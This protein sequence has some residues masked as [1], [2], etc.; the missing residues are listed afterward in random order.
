[1]LG[2]YNKKID[3]LPLE[4]LHYEI[5]KNPFPFPT[6]LKVVGPLGPKASYFSLSFESGRSA[7]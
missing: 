6:S 3:N 4:S 5:E 2:K 7:E 1:M